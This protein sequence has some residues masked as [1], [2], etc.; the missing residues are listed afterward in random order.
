MRGLRERYVLLFAFNMSILVLLSS[1]CAPRGDQAVLGTLS[2][3]STEN[4]RLATEVHW[5][6]ELVQYLATRGP[7]VATPF[8]R[9]AEPTPYRP[10]IGSVELEDGRCCVQGVAGETVDFSAGIE[11]INTIPFNLVFCT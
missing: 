11:A 10:V 7:F 8:P 2:A 4:A 9:D 3:L 1:G 5:Q 6:G